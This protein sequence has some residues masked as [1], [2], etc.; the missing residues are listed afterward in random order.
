MTPDES[1]PVDPRSLLYGIN[2]VPGNAVVVV[3]GVTD[4]WR[5]GYGAV[6]TLGMDWKV[7]QADQLRAFER[8][9]ILFDPGEKAQGRAEELA[10][11]LS[12]FPGITEVVDGLRTDPGDFSD[13]KANRIMQTLGLR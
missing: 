4:V 6:A 12:F 8:R 7:E 3:E 5:L 10:E 11:W 13:T 1:L 9:Y 2:A